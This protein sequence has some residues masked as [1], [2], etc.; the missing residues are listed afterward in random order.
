M[1]NALWGGSKPATPEFEKKDEKSLSDTVV[2]IPGANPSAKDA[3]YHPPE[4]KVVE[5]PKGDEKSD[6]SKSDEK[7]VPTPVPKVKP[8]PSN[9]SIPVGSMLP[10]AGSD[11]PE[12]WI[13]ADGRVVLISEYPELYKVVGKTFE[14]KHVPS[15]EGKFRIP[16]ASGAYSKDDN[17]IVPRYTGTVCAHDIPYHGYHIIKV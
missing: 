16:K 6:V 2:V 15:G 11:A 5:H 1:L 14:N 3:A 7:V 9:G 13:F 12:G 17:P 8:F 4:E 10:F